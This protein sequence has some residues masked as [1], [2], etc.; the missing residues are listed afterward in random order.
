M[1]TNYEYKIIYDSPTGRW[2]MPW[3]SKELR[4]KIGLGSFE[5]K[6]NNLGEDGWEIV[7]SNTASTGSFLFFSI[8]ATVILRREKS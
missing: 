6:L 4:E 8:Q 1:T 3:A 7:S 2:L 5:R